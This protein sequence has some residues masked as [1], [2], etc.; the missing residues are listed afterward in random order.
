MKVYLT[1][2]EEYPIFEPAE[3]GYYY[4]GN[5]MVESEEFQSVEDALNEARKAV[6][7]DGV[8]EMC[9][10]DADEVEMNLMEYQYN[11]WKPCTTVAFEQSRYIGE[12]RTLQIELKQGCAEQGWHPYE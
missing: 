11:G 3:G 6:E 4:A 5:E 10:V 8:L 2:Y 12:G 9:D 1:Y 7:E